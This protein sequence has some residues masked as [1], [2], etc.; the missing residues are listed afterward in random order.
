MTDEVWRDNNLEFSITDRWTVLD[1]Q[2]R[3][4]ACTNTRF[5]CQRQY[6]TT[7]KDKMAT[8][9]TFHEGAVGDEERSGLLNQKG[10]TI[11]LTGLSASGKVRLSPL[12]DAGSSAFK[13]CTEWNWERR[14]EETKTR[15]R[16]GERAD[17][18]S[19][20]ATALEQHLLHKKLHSF[21]LDG[22]NIRF[23]LNKV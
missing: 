17:L 18:Q 5:P 3:R 2:T 1:Q 6:Q 20:I 23:G 9:I 12:Y 10:A 22:D 8:N 21:R 7:D 4:H 15:T 14:A 16:K 11:W 13:Y 19:T